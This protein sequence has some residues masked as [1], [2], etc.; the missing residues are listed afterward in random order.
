[1]KSPKDVAVLGHQPARL[2][3]LGCS[4][5]PILCCTP[6]RSRC[7]ADAARASWFG[8]ILVHRCKPPF[9]N[10]L[11]SPFANSAP[12]AD[13]RA[14]TASGSIDRATGQLDALAGGVQALE[15]EALAAAVA[16]RALSLLVLRPPGC[17]ERCIPAESALG[18][19]RCLQLSTA[20][21]Q[22]FPLAQPNLF[23]LA[24][25]TLPP[26]LPAPQS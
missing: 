26:T 21:G 9:A 16:D 22:S 6:M 5:L 18:G 10:S 3:G 25:P 11:P 19:G 2:P 23:A 13:F 1:M 20:G 24:Q 14:H 12:P 15:E 8:S 17:A 7:V 4:Q